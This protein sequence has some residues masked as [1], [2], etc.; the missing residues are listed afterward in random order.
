[1]AGNGF[2]QLCAGLADQHSGSQNGGRKGRAR[3]TRYDDIDLGL[4]NTFQRAFLSTPRIDRVGA[5]SVGIYAKHTLYWTDWL[6]DHRRL[7]R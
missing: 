4:T 2:G 7:A 6:R 5:G 3:Q 1:M